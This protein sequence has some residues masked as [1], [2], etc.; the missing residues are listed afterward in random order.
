VTSDATADPL[1]LNACP[2]CFYS[3]Q[4]L[5]DAGVF[6]EC[7]E[8]FDRAAVVLH[9]YARG[10]LAH[11]GNAR[12][13]VAFWLLL[14]PF[15]NLVVNPGL[16]RSR[17]IM[18]AFVGGVIIAWFLWRRTRGDA[19]GLVQVELSDAGCRQYDTARRERARRKPPTPWYAIA[20]PVVESTESG[21]TIRIKLAP[22]V[23]WYQFGQSVVD[24]EI[25]GGP[26]LA[27][28]LRARVI[29]WTD[30]A[31]HRGPTGGFP[32]VIKPPPPS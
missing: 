13:W 12:P 1:R 27:R 25:D 4:G 6:P 14:A 11:V 30:R 16:R 24:A 9:G 2:A 7:G 17:W 20:S 3:L 10:S 29:A 23:K 15:L 31:R 8:P 22:N 18:L 19:P 28:A 32:V 26:E 21:R 5:A